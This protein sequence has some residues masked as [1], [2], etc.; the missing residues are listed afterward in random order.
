M[1]EVSVPCHRSQSVFAIP[2]ANYLGTFTAHGEK[3]VADQRAEIQ[4]ALAAPLGSPRLSELAKAARTCVVICSDHTR[5]V[6]SRFIIPAM[7][8]ELHRGNPALDITLLVATGCHRGTT[9]QE[10]EG[11]FGAD[12]VNREKIVVHDCDDTANL[13]GAGILPSGGR[14]ILNRLAM[15]CDLLVAEGFIEPHF[16]AGFSGGRKSVLPG[17]ASRE[18]VLANHCAEFIES[19]YARTG[20]LENNPIHQDMLFA[21]RQAKLAFIVNT[22]IDGEKRIIRAFAGNMEAA[23]LAGTEFCRRQA[24]V[25]VPLADIV[26]TSNGGYPLD[27]NVYQSVKGMTAAESVCREGGV[28]I[29]VAGCSDGHGGDCFYQALK[30]AKS[31]QELLERVKKVPRDATTP[32]QWQ[33]QIL[34]RVLSRF[35]VIMYAP[36][37]PQGMLRDMMLEP[38][39]SPAAALDRAFVLCGSEAKVAVLPDGVSVI[40]DVKG[41]ICL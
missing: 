10:L 6:P 13:T 9:R 34:A 27:M 22:V 39:S 40:P 36:E 5:P 37:C 11:K 15:E 24:K 21:A 8:E 16:F 19:P 3:C 12:I 32:D 29:M 18:T 31:P 14:L 26:I 35:Q 28:I 25:E 41:G 33:Y 20:T 7:L 17:I 4:R 23:H 38:A 1:I 2:E 30:A